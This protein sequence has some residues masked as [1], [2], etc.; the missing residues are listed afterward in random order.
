MQKFLKKRDKKVGLPPGSLVYIGD[1]QPH[2]P[3]ITM[4]NFDENHFDLSQPDTLKECANY[5]NLPG[6]TWINVDGL[7]ETTIITQL[8]ECLGLHPLVMEDILNTDQRPKLEDYGDYIFLVVKMLTYNEDNEE[9]NS[10][11]LSFILGKSYI[12]SFQEGTHNDFSPL[13]ERIKSNKER[14][15]K[16]TADYLLY[17]M[18]DI[19]IDHY[20]ILLEKI[21]EHIDDIEDSLVNLPGSVSIPLYHKFKREMMFLRKSIWPLREVVG[22]LE[23][24]ISPLVTPGTRIYFRDL[25]DHIVQVMDTVENIRDML[26]GLLD[27]YMSTIN[28]KMNEIMKVLTVIAT[29]F[30]PLSFIT[31]VYGMNFKYMPE[32][33]WEWSYPLVWLVMIVI[34]IV[35]LAY[36][37]KKKWI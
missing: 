4:V 20:F 1:K 26:S 33:N 35:M 34:T 2:P 13:V 23:R 32:L 28:Y 12:I 6:T 30:I 37:R 18:L 16:M 24:Q 27:I 29:I 10:E 25:Y 22:S 31:G 15:S 7:N 9:I 3:K 5:K 36:F 19:V 21:G 14:L 11:Q 17:S 8:G